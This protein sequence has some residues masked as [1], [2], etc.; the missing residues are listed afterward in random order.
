VAIA[1]AFDPALEF[2]EQCEPRLRGTGFFVVF[3]DIV[4][5]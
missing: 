2:T 5:S 3:D 4:L 1:V